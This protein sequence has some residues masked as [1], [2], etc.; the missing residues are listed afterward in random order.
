MRASF[1]V[2]KLYKITF[3]VLHLTDYA[4]TICPVT[5]NQLIETLLKNGL[6]VNQRITMKHVNANN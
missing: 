1:E 6:D 4:K 3:F 2:Q 5:M